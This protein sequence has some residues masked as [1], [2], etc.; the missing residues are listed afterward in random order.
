LKVISLFWTSSLS[1]FPV[2]VLLRPSHMLQNRIL[3]S[4]QTSFETCFSFWLI[5]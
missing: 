2:L 1:F 3:S 4:F 5:F